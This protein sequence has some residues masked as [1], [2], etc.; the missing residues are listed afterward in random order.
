MHPNREY[1]LADWLIDT[2]YLSYRGHTLTTGAQPRSNVAEWIYEAFG[3]ALIKRQ[4]DVA[5]V[6]IV[7]LQ[8]TPAHLDTSSSA[9]SRSKYAW[10]LLLYCYCTVTVTVTVV[11]CAR[12]GLGKRAQPTWGGV[13]G[14][15]VT[16]LRGAFHRLSRRCC[17]ADWCMAL[18]GGAHVCRRCSGARLITVV[19]PVCWLWG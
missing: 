17:C 2:L 10:K 12:V 11:T 8:L 3:N 18:V 9:S 19:G 1:K 14:R 13:G 6:A 16:G 15:L 7:N 5:S 4:T